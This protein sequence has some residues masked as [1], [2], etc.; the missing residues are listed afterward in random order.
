MCKVN[1]VQSQTGKSD[2]GNDVFRGPITTF[3]V[4]VAPTDS[5]KIFDAHVE[6]QRGSPTTERAL[7]VYV[8][9]Y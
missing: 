4:S 2:S 9:L 1:K 5:S 7:G 6:L 8:A 3:A